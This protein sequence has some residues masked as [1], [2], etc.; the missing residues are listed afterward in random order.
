MIAIFK[1][2][3]KAY[4][5]SPIGYTFMAVF[6]LVAGLFFWGT[7]ILNRV[8]TMVGVLSNLVVIFLLLVPVLTM[9]LFSEEKANKT[10]Q[11]LIT[12]PVSVPGIVIGKYLAAG[13]VFFITLLVSLFYMGILELLGDPT[14][15]E[16]IGAY[17]GFFLMG[18]AFIAI[19]LFISSLTD[20]QM[21]SAVI[22]FGVLLVLFL[23]PNLT[24]TLGNYAFFENRVVKT[25]VEWLAITH[26]YSDFASGIFSIPSVVYYLSVIAIFLFLTV[27]QIEKRRW[28]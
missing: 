2:E 17:I 8:P 6:F 18:M 4:F 24:A 26:W 16:V 5:I 9:R 28:N 14:W 10:D 19:G 23:L 13:A 25:V 21:V 27:R 12:S 22:S 11:I 3:L 20:N 15:G 7:C 1:R